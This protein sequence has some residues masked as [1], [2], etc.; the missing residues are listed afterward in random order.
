MITCL[1]PF[2]G[3]MDMRRGC[4]RDLSC[5]YLCIWVMGLFIWILSTL[6][7][8][9]NISNFNFFCI[10]SYLNHI[11]LE[12]LKLIEYSVFTFLV[13]K[14]CV[15]NFS[16]MW[17]PFSIWKHMF[18]WLICGDRKKHPFSIMLKMNFTNFHSSQVW[19]IPFFSCICIHTIT[20]RKFTLHLQLSGFQHF[21][22]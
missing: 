12:L 17:K 20:S 3:S 18:S 19:Y 16:L 7:T 9:V 8:P 1:V 13:F 21:R 5:N 4:S 2:V 10:Y 14:A 11:K 22:I 15:R 6:C